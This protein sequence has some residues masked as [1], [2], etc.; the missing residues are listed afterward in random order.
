MGTNKDPLYL[1]NHVII[2]HLYVRVMCISQYFRM[3]HSH[4]ALSRRL[5]GDLDKLVSGI[6]GG[7]GMVMV[8]VFNAF[9]EK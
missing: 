4:S 6:L 9:L 1:H 7:G 5:P 2:H 3:F 8:G